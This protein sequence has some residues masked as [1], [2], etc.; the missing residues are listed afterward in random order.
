MTKAV[1][2]IR[3]K[4]F[5]KQWHGSLN[6]KTGLG[7]LES[8]M[9]KVRQREFFQRVQR[10]RAFEEGVNTHM[11]LFSIFKLLEFTLVRGFQKN[12]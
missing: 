9:D 6:K 1:H 7:M 10:K 5:L 11:K 8:V 12:V 3:L 2:Q 4:R